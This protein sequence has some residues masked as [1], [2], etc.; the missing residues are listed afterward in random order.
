M[1]LLFVDGTKDHNPHMLYEKPTGGTL[2]SLTKVPEYLASLGHEVW[3][4]STYPVRETVNGVHYIQ[5]EDK[6]PKWDVTIFNRNVIPLDFAKYCKENGIKM[7]WWLHDI[8]DTRYLPDAAFKLVDHVVALSQYCKSTFTD[9]YQLRPDCVSVISNGIDPEVYYP[10]KWDE[11]N[12]HTFIMASALIKGY[13]PIDVT[14]ANL[15]MHDP[16]IDFRIY[17]SQKLHGFDNS[18]NQT[19]FLDTMANNGAHIYAPTSQKVMAHI[20]RKAWALL[21]PNSYPEIC[22][23]LLL[24]A[25]ACGL[26]VIS[27][28]IGANPE[29]VQ[30]GVNGLVTTKWH[31]HDIHSWIVEFATK[32][33]QLQ[34]DKDLHHKLS[35]AAPTDVPTWRDIGDKWNEL[36]QRIKE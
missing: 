29:F 24:Q 35:D 15:K 9:F 6:I 14:F 11:R 20:M 12:P 16:D 2:T 22:S 32:T 31:P 27:S 25:K 19:K 21:M 8:V 4:Q 3:V 13:I 1:K 23:N 5:S 7:I 10:G 26:P 36:L 18:P 33:C 30:D 28:N 17:S 34:A